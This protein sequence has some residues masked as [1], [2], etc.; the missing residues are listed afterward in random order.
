MARTEVTGSQ[1]KDNTVSLI[2]DVT[3]ILTVA[4]GGTGSNTLT[5]NNVLLGNGTGAVLAVAPGTIGNVL[6]S[7]GTTWRSVAPTGSVPTFTTTVT[8][9]T[10][11]TLDPTSNSIQE[12]TGTAAQTVT[13]PTTSAVVAG[14]QFTIINNSTGLLTMQSS[15]GAA[16]IVLTRTSSAVFTA[17]VS[18][19]TAA[20]HW[21]VDYSP[22]TSSGSSFAL[23]RTGDAFLSVDSGGA[24][25]ILGATGTDAFVGTQSPHSI[26]VRT[27]NTT[28]ATI[29]T[30]GNL[31]VTG[32]ITANSVPVLTSAP[33]VVSIAS[34]GTPAINTDATDVFVITALEENITSMT[35]NLIGTPANGQKLL[36]RIKGAAAQTIAWGASFVSSGA[37]TLPTLTVAGRTHTVGLIY[38]A[39]ISDWVCVE[40]FDTIYSSPPTTLGSGIRVNRTAATTANISSG[41]NIFP[42]GWFSNI[43]HRTD[44]L[45]Y[46]T[47][48]TNTGKITVSVEG[49]Y[50][51][52][53]SVATPGA[54]APGGSVYTILWKGSGA[55]ARS[56]YAYGGQV[57]FNSPGGT[58]P[59]FNGSFL[60][61]LKAGDYVE[62]G[63][64]SNVS[65]NAGM[66]STDATFASKTCWWSIALVNRSHN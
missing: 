17:L 33:R 50:Q 8:S 57:R 26:N 49:W 60:V 44:D 38:D 24:K 3:D 28:R 14:R 27:G 52:N 41:E 48:G 22:F 45:T 2:A 10:A 12:F 53:L 42:A 16:I 4:N 40:A 51:C 31:A 65:I 46:D 6:T 56:V 47:S 13:L 32:S 63:Y 43:I 25:V 18:T 54:S 1:I 58:G 29:D 19:P 64:F 55:G 37:A 21:R 30:S 9:A 62:P 5:L 59:V 34:S 23:T 11:V 66:G 35:T 39:A 36:V 7:N 20:A 61:Y 15:S